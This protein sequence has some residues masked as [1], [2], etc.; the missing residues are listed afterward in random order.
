[1]LDVLEKE[2]PPINHPLIGLPNATITPHIDWISIEARKRIFT[3][4]I[5]I[6]NFYKNGEILNR[7]N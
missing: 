4:I 6:L 7:V 5:E 3:A 2:P 1:L